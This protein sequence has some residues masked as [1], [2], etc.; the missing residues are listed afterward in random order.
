MI[1]G[2]LRF[3]SRI[4]APPECVVCSKEGALACRGCLA[5]VPSPYEG[6][7]GTW[8]YLDGVI[9][10]SAYRD[11]VKDLITL[12]KYSHQREA[13]IVLGRIITRKV[14]PT[15][16]DVVTSIPVA[17]SRLRL[18]GYNQSE[19]IAKEVSQQLRLPYLSLL[20]R[21]KN[22]QQV[23][24]SRNERLSQ[25]EGVFAVHHSPI[26]LRVL[27]VDDVLTTGATLNEAAGI[28]KRAGARSVW[29]AVGARD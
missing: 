13:A 12:L 11:R 24:K 15:S 23:G 1:S 8:E 27:V 4:I 2:L 9:C 22:I 6:D 26:H 21:V 5:Q 10:A 20:R 25:V 19:L 14:D 28:L 18:R 7:A 16:F 17:S 3:A 29:G